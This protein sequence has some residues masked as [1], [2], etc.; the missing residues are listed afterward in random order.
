ML[1][2]LT[3]ILRASLLFLFV[4][5][6]TKYFNLIIVFH[7][8]VLLYIFQAPNIENFMKVWFL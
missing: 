4:A 8:H 1:L 7:G 3:A 6:F 5:A 2:L